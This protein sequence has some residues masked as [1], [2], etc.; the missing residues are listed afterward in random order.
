MRNAPQYTA[1]LF[2]LVLSNPGLA[3][4]SSNNVK[5]ASLMKYERVI[6][7]VILRFAFGRRTKRMVSC[8]YEDMC[9]H[10]RLPFIIP[11]AANTQRSLKS[12]DR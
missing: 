9:S 6:Q 3:V 5:S 7:R 1:K 10:K 8:L 11:S 4:L 12:I 2:C